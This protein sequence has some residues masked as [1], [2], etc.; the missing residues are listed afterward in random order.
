MPAEGASLVISTD[1]KGPGLERQLEGSDGG[2]RVDLLLRLAKEFLNHDLHRAA[3]Y[4]KE[5]A[6]L[7]RRLHEAQD[8]SSAPESDNGLATGSEY[9]YKRH[10]TAALLTLATCRQKQGDFEAALLELREALSLFK[11]LGDRPGEA[12]AL[13]NFGN[14]YVSTGDYPNALNNYQRSLTIKREL[15]NQTGV[16]KTLINIGVVFQNLGD[17]PSALEHYLQSFA[18][19]QRCGDR[20]GEAQTLISIGHVFE[21]LGDIPNA[22][23]HFNRSYAIIRENGDQDDEARVL[24]HI[25]TVHANRE[26]YQT[27][28]DYFQRSLAIKRRIGDVSSEA[29]L[30]LN[31]GLAC[32]RL[33]DR[34]RALEHYQQSLAIKKE[35][36][37]KRGT[38]ESLL[39]LGTLFGDAEFTHYAPSQAV[40]N[41]EQ[42]L[43][44]AE[45]I[46]ARHLIYEIQKAL[47]HW[48]EREGNYREAHGYFKKYHQLMQEVHSSESENKIRNLQ[49]IHHVEQSRKE[50]EIYRLR[51]IELAALNRELQQAKEQAEA[52]NSH[53]TSVNKNLET[54]NDEK[55]EFLSIVAHDLRNPLTGIILT[56]SMLKNYHRR[57]TG[58]DLVKQIDKIEVTATHMREIVSN[59]LDINTLESGRMN[60]KTEEFD[61]L[62]LLTTVTGL[63]QDRAGVKDITLQFEGLTTESLIVA[64]KRATREVIENLLSNAV[65]F[66]PRGSR[67]GV[68]IQ[69]PTEPSDVNETG[70]V[71]A[72][73][74]RMQVKDE[75]PGIT[76][77]DM[78]KLFGK[79]ARL[80]AKP[81]GG[82]HSTGLGLSI[83]KKLVE[84]MNGRIW[85]SS[86]PGK[87]ASFFV[88]LPAAETTTTPL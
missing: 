40:Q 69:P 12:S 26:D 39:A 34:H 57:M 86:Q 58:D 73:M 36:G 21:H 8:R 5:A 61:L 81:T 23:D 79:F 85:C 47:A 13:N 29:N 6:A 52:L 30:L 2:L 84:A 27:A 3:N 45:T 24:S 7:S 83:A 10:L 66:S 65:K 70:A 25:G 64:D 43:A 82:E 32:E 17:Y 42:A 77:K 67:V 18:I 4:A 16:A 62:K 88:E 49:V 11:E 75:G 55:N 41:L 51:N 60:L 68:R 63:Y 37:D 28:L 46:R 9:E 44:L 1:N 56:A 48:H 78:N 19:W 71:V 72:R 15:D 38:A 35:S 50:T 53:L 20:Q 74:I 54:L 33:G 22:L 14:V 31:I 76:A 80:S 59:L 87:G